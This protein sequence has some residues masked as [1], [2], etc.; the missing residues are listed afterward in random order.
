MK[1]KL[2]IIILLLYP[3][4]SYSYTDSEIKFWDKLLEKIHYPKYS[5][6]DFIPKLKKIKLTSKYKK[7]EN[8]FDYVILE[9]TK[10]KESEDLKNITDLLDS[11]ILE[12]KNPIKIIK[13]EPI[14][15]PVIVEPKVEKIP[16]KINTTSSYSCSKKTCWLMYSCEE[17]YYKLN[18]CWFSWLDSDKDWI[19][20]ESICK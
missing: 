12:D 14:I 9:L 3:I 5:S 16:E 7:Y 1:T 17:A 6:I 18:V 4:H 13:K 19:P 8:I 20:C 10:E 2:L 11:N 15:T